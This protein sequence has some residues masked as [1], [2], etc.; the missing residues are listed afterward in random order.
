ML[1]R[2][3]MRLQDGKRAESMRRGRLRC[4]D[5]GVTAA[6]PSA[7]AAAAVAVAYVI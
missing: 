3:S 2:L 7:A 1:A 6:V 4:D 5:A